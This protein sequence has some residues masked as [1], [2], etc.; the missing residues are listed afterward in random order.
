V[1]D[2][3]YPTYPTY[4]TYLTLNWRPVCTADLDPASG[5]TNA[6]GFATADHRT[7]PQ[8]FWRRRYGQT[9]NRTF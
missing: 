6:H 1:T 3:T 4:L 2:R 5:S 7:V 8:F 9:T